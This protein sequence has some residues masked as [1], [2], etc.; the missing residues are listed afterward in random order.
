[1]VKKIHY[2]KGLHFST[3]NKKKL[4]TLVEFMESL[5]PRLP[6][7]VWFIQDTNFETS[8]M[9]YTGRSILGYQSCNTKRIVTGTAILFFLIVVVLLLMW[10]KPGVGQKLSVMRWVAAG[11]RWCF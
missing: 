5:K 7:D 11:C 6:Y 4:V 2:H 8:I 3:N 9:N 1:L 10:P